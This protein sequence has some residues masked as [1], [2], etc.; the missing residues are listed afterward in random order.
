[1]HGTPSTSGSAPKGGMVISTPLVGATGTHTPVN[2][3]S[4]SPGWHFVAIGSVPGASVSTPTAAADAN[5]ASAAVASIS[6][7]E[8]CTAP[9]LPHR[10]RIR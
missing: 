6:R 3:A 10:V 9:E 2:S 7:G 1:M 4:T 8:V 5:A